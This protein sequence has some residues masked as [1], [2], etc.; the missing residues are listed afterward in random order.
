MYSYQQYNQLIYIIYSIPQI[1]VIVTFLYNFNLDICFR[2]SKTVS[3]PRIK[4]AAF[5][6]IIIHGA[7]V[8][9]DGSLRMTDA[10]ATR[11]FNM[12]FTLKKK[13]FVN[14]FNNYETS[15]IRN[16]KYA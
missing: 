10:S 2:K 8:F 5:S 15:F 1:L 6:P 16:L 7:F 4:S 12:P 3:F 13:S 11:K 14:T 9:P